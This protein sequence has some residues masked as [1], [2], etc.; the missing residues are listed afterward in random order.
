V[1]SVGETHGQPLALKDL[2]SDTVLVLSERQKY[3]LGSDVCVMHL[4]R[5]FGR[6][7]EDTL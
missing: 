6:A 1:Q 4:L 7:M 5:K 3:V 2:A